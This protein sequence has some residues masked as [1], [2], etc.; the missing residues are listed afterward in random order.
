MKDLIG[1]Q[2]K[3]LKIGHLK[4]YYKLKFVNTRYFFFFIKE[5]KQVTHLS[6]TKKKQKMRQ[7]KSKI[8][9]KMKNNTMCV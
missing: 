2:K 9:I 8:K 5:Q 4:N 6:E 7:Y 3:T 1:S